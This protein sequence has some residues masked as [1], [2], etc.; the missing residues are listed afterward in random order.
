MA[1]EGGSGGRNYSTCVHYA[2]LS[3]GHCI[4]AGEDRGI[5]GG[6]IAYKLIVSQC[7]CVDWV[8]KG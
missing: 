4:A 2:L 3:H 8:P 7:L 6:C 5:Q 1:L